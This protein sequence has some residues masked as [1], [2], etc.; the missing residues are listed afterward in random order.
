MNDTNNT[1]PVMT[2]LRRRL[3][4]L[5]SLGA[6]LFSIGCDADMAAPSGQQMPPDAR[7]PELVTALD[8]F[9]QAADPAYSWQLLGT[10]KGSGYTTYLL[11]MKSGSWR[12][13]SEVDRPLW[14]HHV[15]VVVPENVTPGPAVLLISG[16]SNSGGPPTK[17]SGEV[18]TLAKSVGAIT[19]ELRQ[20]PNQPLTFA[21]H[22]GK[23]HSEDG[24]IAFGWAQVIKT[25]DPTWHARFAMVR[26]AVR[27]MD[28]TQAFL[29]TP[30]G[31]GMAPDKFIVAGA[32]KRGWTTWLTAAVDKRV[33]AVLPIVIDVLNV[34]K[35]MV[36]H[37]ETYGFW[38]RSLYD[39]HYN[40]VTEQIGTKAAEAMLENED[41]Y[42]FRRRLT[43]PKYMLNATGD[44][45]FLPDGSKNYFDDLRGEKYM[46]YVPNADHSLDGSDAVD[47]AIAFVGM[48]REGRQRPAFSWT[49]EGTDSIRVKTQEA[50]QKVLLWQATNPNARDFR[51]ET[52][53]KVWK[54]SVL[55]SQGEG[56]YTGQVT[57]PGK[58]YTAFVVE[59]HFD[60]GQIFP[61]KV[62]TAVRVV[63]DTRPFVGIDPKSAKLE[64][65]PTM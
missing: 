63:P 43:M 24:I 38:A 48:L 53:G 47:G 12:K 41:P 65:P 13:S 16:G 26:A 10:E 64:S 59:L 17:A 58:G 15:L 55:S 45:F 23:A 11:D 21:G 9:V 57:M 1:T 44:Q 54:S 30:Q 6:L 29:K 3:L 32:S 35:F 56:V 28:A 18:V 46:R 25:G 14:Q 51:V 37:V 34:N 36:Q 60:S 5:L 52:L 22:D 19:V 50:P 42:Y 61:L 7:E 31:G 27:A 20:I 4:P 8:R 62:S 39:Y 33:S 2:F 40:K 49:F